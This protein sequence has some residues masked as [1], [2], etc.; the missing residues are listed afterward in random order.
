MGG[1]LSAV[2]VP[3]AVEHA[4]QV[5]AIY[6]AGVD[7]GNAT[8]ETTAPAWEAF[9]AAKLP[10]HRFAAVEG[11]G[12]VLGWVAAS[13]VS[14]RC[15]YAGVV[16]HSVYVHPAA[17]A[18][19]IASTLLRAL[20]ESTERAGIWTIQS[21]I[22]PENAAS[23]AVHERAGFRVIGTRERIGRH[24]GV[25]RDVVLVERRSPAIT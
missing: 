19:G 10:E 9:D 24:H 22:F 8:F 7:E 6:R 1:V 23:L 13:R 14:D 16:E 20:I 18:R 3:L 5:L 25:W 17:R 15:S 11:N 2:V 12:K 4:E 21:G